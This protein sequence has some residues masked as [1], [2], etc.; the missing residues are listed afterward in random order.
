[1]DVHKDLVEQCI[2][3][4]SK[5]QRALYDALK[6]RLFGICLRYLKNQEDANDA[7]QEAMIRLFK[8][9]HRAKGIANF[10]GWV[11]TIIT[12]AA[13]DA[14]KRKRSEMVV[15]IDESEV[16]N[17]TSDEVSAIEILETEE[18]L[19]LLY[20]LPTNQMVSFNLY[21]IDGY[22]HKEIAEKL[23]IAEST[24]RVLLTRAKKGMIALLKKTEIHEQS[25]G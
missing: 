16:S 9:I 24:S 4:D 8:N 13:I 3:G 19:N 20:Q 1:M 25:Y 12:N 21:M 10:N 6:G 7:F 22:S 11:R 2:A 15:N 23:E 17:F 5:S 14:Y 18:I